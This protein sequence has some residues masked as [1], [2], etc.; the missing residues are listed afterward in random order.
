M[1]PYKGEL[2]IFFLKLFKNT[3]GEKTK[4]RLWNGVPQTSWSLGKS[5]FFQKVYRNAVIESNPVTGM[6]VTVQHHSNVKNT[7][8]WLV[9]DLACPW[10]S[11]C[12]F[13]AR[14]KKAFLGRTC[15]RKSPVFPNPKLVSSF[16]LCTPLCFLVRGQEAWNH[17]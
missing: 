3:D 6:Q 15:R 17:G 11:D 16:Q 5:K 8:I 1:L 4:R 7:R 2:S 14:V 9:Y 10:H 12:A 13:A